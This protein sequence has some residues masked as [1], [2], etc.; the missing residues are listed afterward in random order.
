VPVSLL[1][2]PVYIFDPTRGSFP[3]RQQ[4]VTTARLYCPDPGI[5]G[6]TYKRGRERLR[7][8]ASVGQRVAGRDAPLAHRRRS[9][10]SSCHERGNIKGRGIRVAHSPLTVQELLH[11]AAGTLKGVARHGDHSAGMFKW[12]RLLATLSANCPFGA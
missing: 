7:P 10:V 8:T 6:Q 9:C 4:N 12:V 1:S 11:S 5:P 3:Y 2:R